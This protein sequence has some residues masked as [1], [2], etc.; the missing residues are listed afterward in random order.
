[1][2]AIPS[3]V[4]VCP[5]KIAQNAESRKRDKKTRGS[6]SSCAPLLCAMLLCL[7]AAFCAG[8]Q[9]GGEKWARGW[10]AWRAG[11]A[12]TAAKEWSSRPL[13]A[14]FNTGA[15]RIY[16]WKIRALEKLG[17]EKEAA[18]TASMMALRFPLDFYSIALAHE[19]HY[20]FLTRAVFE[21]CG[22]SS[23][24]RR[25]EKEISA[26]SAKTGVSKNILFAMVRQESNFTE[27]A[28]SRSGAVGLMQLMPPTAREA[29]SRLKNDGLSPSNPAHNIMLGA[30][31]FAHLNERFA[32]RL[33]M[34]LAAYNAGAG[35]VSS[36]AL[37]A[38]SW[39]EWIEEIPYRETRVYVRSVLKNYEIY[40]ATDEENGGEER[41]FFAAGRPPAGNKMAALK[42]K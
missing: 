38:G 16:Y 7:A 36:W 35:S 10:R 21:A 17:R 29:A 40:I 25:W 20:P 33:P 19:G 31:H 42:E 11:D 14:P 4:K 24:P 28:V 5:N 8:R 26:A 18:T 27:R 32:R 15:P 1:M 13:S 2:H 9:C 22:N 30:S 3:G 39:V 34:A 6:S 41:S 37:Y 12:A 23:Y